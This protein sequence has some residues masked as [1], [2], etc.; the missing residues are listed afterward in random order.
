MNEDI[1]NIEDSKGKKKRKAGFEQLW[2]W[3]EAHKLM[4]E[5][6]ESCKLLPRDERFRLRD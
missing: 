4:N 3:Q 1:E 6:A 5:I 2:I